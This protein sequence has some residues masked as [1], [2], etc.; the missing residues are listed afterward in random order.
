MADEERIRRAFR[1]LFYNQHK[2]SHEIEE[3]K[4]RLEELEKRLSNIYRIG[5]N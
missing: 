5:D 4:K 1:I 2:M 3:I